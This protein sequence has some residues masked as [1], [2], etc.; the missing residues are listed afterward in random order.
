MMILASLSGIQDYLFD[1][2]EIGGGQARALRARSFQIQIMSECIAR[3]LLG[4]LDL[5]LDQITLRAA[6]KK[7]GMAVGRKGSRDDV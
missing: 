7:H 4:V 3:R 1:V 5:H 2:H 6:A